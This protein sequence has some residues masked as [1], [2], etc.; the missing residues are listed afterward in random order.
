M[1]VYTP[2]TEDIP[3]FDNSVFPSANGTALTIATG[4]K[5]FLS[6]PVA[7]GSEIFPANI[8]L[9]S[10]LTDSLSSKGA[11]G[12]ILSST[13]TGVE[14]ANAG[15]ITGNLEIDNPYAIYADSYYQ[16]VNHTLGNSLNLFSTTVDNINI[17]G[18]IPAGKTLKLGST[19]TGSVHCSNIDFEANQMNHATSPAG[20]VI[21]IGNGQTTGQLNIGTGGN[22]A[23]TTTRTTG[24]I[25][26][27]NDTTYYGA[28]SIGAN[29]TTVTPNLPTILIGSNNTTMSLVKGFIFYRDIS[30]G[31]GTYKNYLDG[32]DIRTSFYLANN[33]TTGGVFIGASQT[34]TGLIKLGSTVSNTIINNTLNTVGLISADGGLAV[35]GAS[36]ITTSS[37]AISSTSGNITTAGTGAI[38]TTGSGSITTNTGNISSTSGNITTAGTGAI[39]TTGTGSISTASGSISSTGIV[40]GTSVISPSFNASTALLDVGIATTQ[41]S[42]VLNIG[43]GARLTS[44]SGGGINIG[45]NGTVSIPINIG[46]G[47]SSAGSIN[48][49][50]I[51]AIAGSTTTNINTSSVSTGGLNLGTTT[52]ASTLK[53]STLALSSATTLGITSGTTMSINCSASNALSIGTSGTSAITLGASGITTTSTGPLSSTGLLTATAGLT[54]GSGKGIT[55]GGAVYSP[56]LTSSQIGYSTVIQN[57]S[58]VNLTSTSQTILTSSNTL[59]IGVYLIAVNMNVQTWSPANLTNYLSMTWSVTTGCSVNIVPLACAGTNTLTSCTFSGV[60]T[61]TSATNTITLAG[62]TNVVGNTCVIPFVSTVGYAQMS[63]CRIA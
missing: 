15:G 62:F 55:C 58:Q 33:T 32:D 4:Q 61:V 47:A 41:T 12:Q 6:Y 44:G 29:S 63:V 1:A 39:S 16:A 3:I 28:I 20:G 56:A 36:T 25:N 57:T 42:G 37:G 13:G 2:P 35:T 60:L 27:G 31:L 53:G 59:P 10:S 24:A 51:G 7:Q 14:W 17:G 30:G 52:G 22:S 11:V 5:Y 9:Q 50:Q 23:G 46:G 21:R 49:G 48:I 8:T 19:S 18:S 38:S 54:L 45:T 26:I 40:T 34:S 43:T